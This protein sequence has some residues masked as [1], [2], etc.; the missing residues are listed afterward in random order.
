MWLVRKKKKNKYWGEEY[1]VLYQGRQKNFKSSFRNLNFDTSH[2]KK[3][4]TLIELL[5]STSI[6]GIIGLTILATF[7]SGFQVYER[8][9]NFGGAQAEILLA[10][11]EIERDL[12]NV[13]TGRKRFLR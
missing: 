10:L 5:V 6:L 12:R 4:F 9:D 1:Q 8:V 7:G 3:G 11:E 2:F 13:L